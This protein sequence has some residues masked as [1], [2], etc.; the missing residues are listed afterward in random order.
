ME[1]VVSRFG[2][3]DWQKRG[4]KNSKENKSKNKRKKTK[5]KDIK[6][7]QISNIWYNH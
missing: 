4:K 6:I 2:L 3:T 1:I 5:K 7:H